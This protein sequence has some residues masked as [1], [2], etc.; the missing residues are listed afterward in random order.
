M[1]RF[2]Y[3]IV[4]LLGINFLYAEEFTTGG[5]FVQR[6][7]SNLTCNFI[8]KATNSTDRVV[9]GKTY[10]LDSDIMEIKT[11]TGEDASL[12]FSTG[13]QLR[14]LPESTFS[15]DAFNQ[16]VLN[17]KSQPSVLEAEYSVTALTLMNGELEIIS[18]KFDTNS[19]CI[20]QTP[21][22]NV[23]L[24]EGRLLIK[25]NPKYL[26]LNVIQG[27][28]TVIDA[29][30]KKTV[31]DKGSM[32]LII[33]YPGREDEIM[34]TSKP[35]SLSELSKITQSI[36]QI[37]KQRKNVMFIVMDKKVVGVQLK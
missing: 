37:E 28:V 13:L 21:L 17:D 11:K 34:V 27:S 19:Q 7:S 6:A 35:I 16:L 31:I 3:L 18:P 5:I 20:L 12:L 25:S 26:M 23:N 32:G 10:L 22:V 14:I 15:I 2:L 36:E 8:S 29:K 30:N 1:K 24:T 4:L 9:V 33:P